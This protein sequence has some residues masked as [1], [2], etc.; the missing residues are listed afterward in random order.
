MGLGFLGR[1]CQWIL[2]IRLAPKIMDS[3]GW[4][5]FNDG[6]FLFAAGLDHEHGLLAFH[7]RRLVVLEAVL[8]N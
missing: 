1:H 2:D 6:R 4:R 5:S 3:L 8:T 7:G